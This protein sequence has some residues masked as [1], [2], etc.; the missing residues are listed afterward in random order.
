MKPNS[1]LHCAMARRLGA[2]LIRVAPLAVIGWPGPSLAAA[3][4]WTDLSLRDTS[5]SLLQAR[6]IQPE[7]ARLFRFDSSALQ[8]QLAAADQGRD[9]ISLP[10]PDGRTLTFQLQRS[11]VMSPGLAARYPQIRTWRGTAV[12]DPQISGRFDYG[13]RGFHGLVSTPQGSVYIDPLLRGDVERHQSYFVRDMPARRRVA[14]TVLSPSA[15]ARRD[16]LAAATANKGVSIAG[17]LRTYRLALATTGEYAQF[18]DPNNATPDKA[19][20]LAEL[21]NVV[22]RVTGV[23]ERELGIRLQLIDNNDEL[24]FTN[25]LLDPYVNEDGT[26]MVTTNTATLN[27]RVGEAA[28]DIGHVVSTGGGG[29][30]GL[31]VVCSSDKGA[32]VT[33]LSAPVGDPFYIDYVAHEMG[34]QFGANHT[35]N[36]EAG[37]CGGGNRN[38]DTAYEPGSG[39]TIMA[40]AGICGVDNIANQSDAFFH[41]ASFDEIVAYTRTN[42]GNSCGVLTTTGNRAPVADAGPSGLTIPKQTPF[43]LT[44]S[45]TDADGDVLR[46]QWEQFDLGAAGAPNAPDATAPLFRSFAPSTSP[47]RTFPQMADVLLGTPRLGESLP[48]VARDLNFRFVVRDGRA[49]NADGTDAGGVG[50]ADRVVKVTDLAGPFRVLTPA[51]VGARFNAGAT[52][53]VSWDVA[54]TTA[55]PVS[56]ASVDLVLLGVDSAGSRFSRVLRSATPNDGADSVELPNLATTQGRVLARCS[57]GLFFNVSPV[58]FTLVAPPNRA[59]LAALSATPASGAP[60]LNVTLDASASGDP[61]LGDGIARYRFDFGDGSTAVEQASP[62]I[63]HRYTALGTYTASVVATDRNGV[64]STP[65]TATVTVATPSTNSGGGGGGGAIGG[66]LLLMLAGAAAVR[67]RARG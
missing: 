32:G 52:L 55:T 18:H 63:S 14:D 30:A 51:E 23:Y 3:P 40:Y 66:G 58:D 1:T 59:P 6:S 53:P 11:D 50:S 67:R 62:R 22:N 47:T 38:A 37:A 13:P 26:S 17:D 49:A 7:R 29:V 20:V 31:G 28:Y 42:T 10:M 24:I 33:G 16:A 4:A 61:D 36:S 2:L 43:E 12:G 35:F 60:E 34:H 46:Y 54:G 27:M 8:A 41:S 56:C 5:S 64:I 9:T 39:S 48:D 57:T 21:V 19:V 25:P 45:G 15:T 65:A 44:G